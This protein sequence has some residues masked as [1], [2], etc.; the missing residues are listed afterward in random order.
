MTAPELVPPRPTGGIVGV[1][2]ATALAGV[3]I[4]LFVPLHWQSSWITLTLGIALI[5][6]FI[7]Q[8]AYGRAQRFIRRT[9]ITV[10]GSLLIL[11]VIS[12][13]AALVV[14]LRGL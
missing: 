6:A 13:V 2:I 8:L 14:L 11:G 12:A 9:A 4:V 10:L 3:G 5:A 1:W 7:V